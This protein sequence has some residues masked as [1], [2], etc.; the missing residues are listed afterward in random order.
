MKRWIV[1]IGIA[2]ALWLVWAH[3]KIKAAAD[4]GQYM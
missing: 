2:V 4:A 1:Y 3:F